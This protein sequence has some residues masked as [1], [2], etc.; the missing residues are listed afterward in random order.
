MPEELMLP[1]P[2]PLPPASPP[3]ADPALLATVVAINRQLLELLCDCPPPTRLARLCRGLT[4]LARERLARCPY[5]L[6]DCGLGTPERWPL[7][8]LA[9][10]AVQDAAGTPGYFH[11]RA[12]VALVRRTLLFAWHLARATP[13]IARLLLG[14]APASVPRLAACRLQDLEEIAELCPPWIV[15]RWEARSPVWGQ[16]VQAAD[17]APPALLQLTQ[18]RGLQLL[19]AD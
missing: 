10:G 14:I 15:P 9:G 13:F 12:G 17:A 2:W 18:L 11:S 19:A 4:P 8:P 16:L 6:I 5:V 7:R 3:A 1:L